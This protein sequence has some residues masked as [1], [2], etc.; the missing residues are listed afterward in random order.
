MTIRPFVELFTVAYDMA[1]DGGAGT[2]LCARQSGPLEGDVFEGALPAGRL[3]SAV[4]PND[5]Q[6]WLAYYR[7]TWNGN[8]VLLMQPDQKGGLPNDVLADLRAR[9]ADLHARPDPAA[10]MPEDL[11][12]V[13]SLRRMYEVILGE[14]LMKDTFRRRVIPFLRGTGRFH[15]ELGRPAELF[16][17]IAEEG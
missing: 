13:R 6:V 12:T 1:L 9:Y 10:L 16:E 11:F 17:L 7:C 2:L 14:P 5:D 4:Q 3:V 8:S 15:I